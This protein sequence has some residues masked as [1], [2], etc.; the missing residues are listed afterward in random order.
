MK[1]DPHQPLVSIITP[2][3]NQETY[4]DEAI[5]SVINQTYAN[6]E[7][8]LVND[9]STDKSTEI[10]KKYAARYPEKIVYVEHENFL[11][12]GISASRNLGLQ[13]SNGRFLAFLDADD[14]YLPK[15]LESQMSILLAHPSAAMLYSS[16][17]YWYSWTRNPEDQEKDRIWSLFGVVPDQLL[18]PPVLLTVFLNNV[19]A[20]PCMGSLL[21]RKEALEDTGGW[22]SSFRGLYEDQ[23]LYSKIAFKY[24]IFVSSGCWDKYRQHPASMCHTAKKDGQIDSAK[25]TYLIWL[26]NYLTNGGAA[27]DRAV[28]K[29]LQNALLPFHYPFLNT[30]KM[31]K[32]NIWLHVKKHIKRYL[33]K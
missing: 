26:K 28:R 27:P 1:K 5:V 10:A 6:W 22:E 7:L 18:H 12:K 4:V 2:L 20:I 3:F 14:I 30:L 32:I 13:K 31:L 21:L 24:P 9:G 23:V 25:Y 17:E 11:N 16:T 33:F 29:A 15:K 8:I 19:S